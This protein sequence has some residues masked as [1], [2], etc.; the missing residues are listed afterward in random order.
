MDRGAAPLEQELAS[1]WQ[2]VLGLPRVGVDDNFVALGGT[3]VLAGE[4]VARVRRSFGL[5]VAVRDVLAGMTI[6]EMSKRPKRFERT[7]VAGVEASDA[8]WMPSVLQEV[9][10]ERGRPSFV[11]FLSH[12]TGKV[13]PDRMRAA[14]DDLTTRHESLRLEFVDTDEGWRL[15]LRPPAPGLIPFSAEPRDPEWS[16][17]ELVARARLR[18]RA[19]RESRRS[20]AEVVH[21]DGGPEHSALLVLF[22]HLVFDGEAIR[23]FLKELA[24]CYTG[25]PADPD[26]PFVSFLRHAQ[27]ERTAVRDHPETVAYWREVMRELGPYPRIDLPGLAE[28]V[29]DAVPAAARA[30]HPLD[31]AV[32]HR[33]HERCREAATTPLIGYLATLLVALHHKIGRPQRIG[34]NTAASRRSAPGSENVIGLF[35]DE[36]TLD[37]G[38]GTP[39]FDVAL[40]QV[41]QRVLGAVEHDVVARR[42]LM[43]ALSPDAQIIRRS[44]PYLWFSHPVGYEALEVSL[45]GD[46]TLSR[47]RLVEDLAVRGRPYPGLGLE[48]ERYAGE[49]PRLVCEYAPVEYPAEEA[50]SLLAEWAAA[51]AR[52]A[53]R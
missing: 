17:E 50:A 40:A 19:F 26:E 44:T 29:P 22:E 32:L 8:L 39:D 48:V 38:V 4:M 51:M 14:L 35:A 30:E 42:D 3:S 6:S 28:R 10:L 33:L 15:R 53:E 34:I 25:T 37:L 1:L 43:R 24:R 20:L 36:M 7:A 47:T 52:A 18:F 11:A 2:G 27:A 5:D 45:G 12:L 23:V 9:M 21:Y 13:D 49:T 16:T 31:P 46:A 41:R